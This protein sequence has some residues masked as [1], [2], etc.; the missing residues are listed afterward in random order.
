M[1]IKTFF[2]LASNVSKE[3]SSHCLTVETSQVM[4]SSLF[5][6]AKLNHVSEKVLHII[7]VNSSNAKV[8]QK[9][10]GSTDFHLKKCYSKVLLVLMAKFGHNNNKG[11]LSCF[12]FLQV[13]SKK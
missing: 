11:L 7:S 3:S 6:F 8:T 4:K 1:Q 5:F 10:N 2:V 13:N 12:F 9:V